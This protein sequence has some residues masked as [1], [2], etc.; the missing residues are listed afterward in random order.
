MSKY[1]FDLTRIGK[2]QHP[3]GKR[4]FFTENGQIFERFHTNDQ[5]FQ[6]W[7]GN[8]ENTCETGWECVHQGTKSEE[9]E[10]IKDF[11][12]ELTLHNISK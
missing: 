2:C 7:T 9:V 3:K 4:H 5:V 1:N 6:V 8:P 10:I 11:M 12:L